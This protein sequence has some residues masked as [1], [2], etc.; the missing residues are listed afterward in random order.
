MF[1]LEELTN[2]TGKKIYLV[3]LVLLAVGMG[4]LIGLTNNIGKDKDAKKHSPTSICASLF[5]SIFVAYALLKD[6][7]LAPM[8]NE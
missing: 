2:T 5:V 4:C 3:M 7:K 6:S 1:N 8:L